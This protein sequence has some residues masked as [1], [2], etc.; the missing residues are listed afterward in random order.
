MSPL[1]VLAI[2]S[3]VLHVVQKVI[4]GHGLDYYFT[5]QGVKFNYVGALM[6]LAIAGV[7]LLIGFGIRFWGPET[8]DEKKKDRRAKRFEQNN[9]SPWDL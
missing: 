1:V 3:G 4:S 2:L 5:G 6:T 7:G 9:D 8:G